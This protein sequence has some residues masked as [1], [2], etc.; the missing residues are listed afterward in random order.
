MNIFLTGSTGFIG[1]RMVRKLDQEGHKIFLLVRPKS[2]KKAE[3]L[4][5]EIPSITYI[6]G[7]IED[8]DVVKNIYTVSHHI[9]QIDCLVH[10]AAHYDLNATLAECY[11]KNVLGTQNIIHLMTKM[12]NLKHFHYFSTYAVNPSTLGAVTEDSLTQDDR[13]FQDEYAKTK[14]HAEHLVRR[15]HLSH[16]KTV[17]HRP[18]IIIGNSETGEMDRSDGIYYFFNFIKKI[19]NINLLKSRL[20]LL[21]MLVHENSYLPLLPVNIL[22]EWSCKIISNPPDAPLRCYHLVPNINIRTKSFMEASME[23]MG[24]PLKIFPVKYTKL[25]APLLPLVKIPKEAAFYM[26]QLSVFQRSNLAQDYPTLTCPDFKE[27][28]PVIIGGFLE[29]EK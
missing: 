20:P 17:I 26:N 18:G 15:H 6:E 16:V 2:R 23:Q 5:R 21:P 3:S 22:T 14:N 1:Q 12:K 4:F 8:T 27:Y 10:L 13:L 19:K 7:D 24:F 28:L 25:L 11:L 9:D 29:N